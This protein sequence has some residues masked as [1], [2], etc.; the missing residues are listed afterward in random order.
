VERMPPESGMSSFA[1][2]EHAHGMSMRSELFPI[3]TCSCRYTPYAKIRVPFVPAV[4]KP[5]TRNELRWN[6]KL[7]QACS[8]ACSMFQRR[9]GRLSGRKPPAALPSR[10]VG[11]AIRLP[12]WLPTWLPAFLLAW[13]P[14]WL[15]VMNAMNRPLAGAGNP[16]MSRPATRNALP[17]RTETLSNGAAG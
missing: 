14:A 11:H 8:R 10:L 3:R 5:F 12:A 4:P 13:L 6:K 16:L 15:P 7:F 9:F 17:G 2:H 1:W